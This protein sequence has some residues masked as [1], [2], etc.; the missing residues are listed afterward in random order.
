MARLSRGE[1]ELELKLKQQKIDQLLPKIREQDVF[2]TSLSREVAQH[3]EK[4][5]LQMSDN[6]NKSEVGCLTEDL[7]RTRKELDQNISQLSKLE[8]DW[9]D[10]K[11][12]H[13]IT[14]I[15]LEKAKSREIYL[16]NVS[17][18]EKQ[19]SEKQ[20]QQLREK[21]RSLTEELRSRDKMTT[22][23]K[24]M[25]GKHFP[26]SEKFQ[27]EIET[28]K[29]EKNSYKKQYEEI[30]QKLKENEE[31]HVLLKGKER[32]SLD[33][34]LKVQVEREKCEIER[35][36]LK[37]K[38]TILQVEREKCEI[39]RDALKEKNAILQVERERCEIERDTLKEKN[40]IL[41]FE[42]EKY[43]IERDRLY[44]ENE[45]FEDE[46]CKMKE[47]KNNLDCK[48]DKLTEETVCLKAERDQFKQEK[49]CLQSET[50]KLKEEKHLLQSDRDR[51]KEEK[52]CM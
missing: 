31:N 7:D 21:I 48:I 33:A 32:E 22:N 44:E 8:E 19:A 16:S 36:G 11:Q 20:E 23:F 2:I 46:L 4:L 24:E 34:H 5:L 10:E 40:G 42:R 13:M 15:M 6:K 27:N 3:R 49:C 52:H 26:E 1:F 47:E 18:D 50:D 39:E 29:K 9:L 45:H 43:K 51:L 14:K 12:Q 30:L 28:L 37:E 41:Q 38:N 17:N 25:I 35:D